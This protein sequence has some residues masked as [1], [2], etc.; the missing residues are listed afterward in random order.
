ML[1]FVRTFGKLTPETLNA[2][3]LKAQ[4]AVRGPIVV[5]AKEIADQLAS[6]GPEAGFDF[7][8]VISCNIGNPQALGQKPNT[9]MS[10]VLALV[11]YPDLLKN[12]ACKSAFPADAIDR[13]NKY[14]GQIPD[15]IGAYS[16]SQGVNVVR[17]EVA[18]FIEARDGF[19]ADPESI[20]LT[21]GA[22]S[23]VQMVIQSLIRD[24]NDGLL[25]PVPQYPLYSASIALCD[26]S[27][28]GYEL[29]ETQGWCMDMDR[30]KASLKEARDNGKTVRALVVINPGNPTG[31][32]MPEEN[33]REVIQL[34]KDEG[35]VLMA[36]EVY[37]ENIYTE[38]PFHSFKKVMMGMG[39]GIA[40]EVE[41]VSFHSTSK[42]FLGE[43][44]KRGGY[45]ELC[46]FDAGVVEQLYKLASVRLCSNVIG[47]LTVGLMVN[48]PKEG[49]ESYD[50][51]TAERSGI[52]DSLARRAKK[53]VAALND[54]PGVSCNDAEGA[55]YAFPQ[56][57]L[58]PKAVEDAASKGLAADAMYCMTMLEKTGIVVVPGSGFGQEEGSYHFRTTFLPSENDIDAVIN[59]LSNFHIEFME[60]YA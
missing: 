36:D 37:Q 55:M 26:G 9:F 7:D 44:G 27:F 42:G 13:A 35:L 46:N 23:G 17:Q 33:I 45:M 48:P 21:D 2:A 8:S 18:E 12:E 25:V 47:Q 56:I 5:R 30:V 52:L 3:V 29:D 49:S 31:Q 1:P 24:E 6:K 38:K 10:Q 41:L 40:D 15:Q 57:T 19:P 20:Y 53:L 60:K 4:Y 54:L 59:R 32:C 34:C 39:A 28:V 11:Q 58:P 50:G 51:Y 43:C 16:H 22:S 14:V